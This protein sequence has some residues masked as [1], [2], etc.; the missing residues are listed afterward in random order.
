MEPWLDAPAILITDDD[1]A[2][3]ET[4]QSVFEPRGFRT[5]LAADGCQAVEW[6][7]QREI[8]VALLDIQMPRMN[9]LEALQQI[10]QRCANLPC[11]LLSGTADASTPLPTDAFSLLGKPI[12]HQVVIETVLSALRCTYPHEFRL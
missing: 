4:L 5:Y 11:I 6:V 8:H 10:R 2:F 12:S 9:G 3:R 7:A 1:R